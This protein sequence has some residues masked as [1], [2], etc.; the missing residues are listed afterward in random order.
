MVTNSVESVRSSP[1]WTKFRARQKVSLYILGVGL[2]VADHHQHL[3]GVGAPAHQRRRLQP[4]MHVLLEGPAADRRRL[5]ALDEADDPRQ[6]RIGRRQREGD[7]RRQAG[8]VVLVGRDAD[9]HRRHQALQ[10][11]DDA[12]HR[13]RELADHRGH[14]R[15]GV[16]HEHQIDRLD[17]LLLG[18]RPCVHG[19]SAARPAAWP[20]APA[21]QRARPARPLPPPP[22]RPPPA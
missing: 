20:P 9:A 3:P 15:G 18:I 13:D 7:H 14:A 21:P 16:D 8:V 12:A 10:D 4:E 19:R 1:P 11:P 2:G 17:H 22:R 5:Q 6:E